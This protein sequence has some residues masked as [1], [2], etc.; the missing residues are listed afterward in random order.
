[1]TPPPSIAPT[2]GSEAGVILERGRAIDRFIVLGLVGRGGMGE[3]YAAYDPELDRKVAIKLLRARD[4]AADAKTRLLREAQAIAKLQ[5]PNV[6]VVYDVGTFGDSVFIAMEF[7]EGRTVGGWLEAGKRTRR[8]IMDVYL[9]AGRGLAAAHAAGLV[10][11]DFKPDN[12][13]VTDDGQVRVMDFGLARQVREAADEAN[14]AR[15]K[16]EAGGGLISE[17]LDPGYDPDA[18]LDF[19]KPGAADVR[20]TSGKYLSVK[21]TQTGAMLG[22]PAYMAPEQFAVRPTDARTDQFA[23]CVAVYEALYGQRPFEGTTMVTLMTSVTTGIVNP[24]PPK[25]NVPGWMRKVLL[26]GLQPHP[27][28]RFP[29]MAGLLAALQTDPTVRARRLAAGLGLAAC[30]VAAIW[31]ARSLEGTQ[32]AVCRGAAGHFAG[33]WEPGERHSPRR[34]AIHDAFVRTGKAYAPQAFASVTRL[35]D[36]YVEK[37]M[38]ADVEA[39]EATHVRGEQSNE[40]LDLRMG[41]LQER[42]TSVHALT[43]L[44]ANA[45][46]KVVENAVGAASALPPLDRCSDVPVLKAVIKPPADP[47]TVRRVQSVRADLARFVALRDAGHC[48]DAQRMQDAL[49]GSARA[50]G[51]QPLLGETLFEAARLGD[52]CGDQVQMLDLFRESV[53]VALVARHDEVAASA[54]LLLAGVLADRVRQPAAGRDWLRVGR[55]LLARLG[56]RPQVEAWGLNSE[57]TIFAAEGKGAD[58]LDAY[59]RALALKEHVVGRDNYDTILGLMNVGVGF[60]YAGKYEESRATSAASREAMSRLLGPD[61]PSVALA[62]NNEGESLNFLHR[63]AEAH[64]AFQRAYDIWRRSEAD[65]IFLSY[66]LTGLGIAYLGEGKADEAVAPL[67]EALRV[68]VAKQFDPERVG[69]TRFALARALWSRPADRERA[70]TLARQ[71]LADYAQVKTPTVPPPDVAAWLR[72]PSTRA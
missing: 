3:V 48:G 49:I 14:A 31:G 10:H 59:Q 21:L 46:G 33:I 30:I 23:F 47:A 35:L 16:L 71:A 39:C 4:N 60:E 57:A 36:G 54:A 50:T 55:A 27:D 15:A 61:H 66:A 11:R 17:T 34:A 1:M 41:C 58:S 6:V 56:G 40:V 72:A 52:N 68:R 29:S 51:Y 8:E 53:T 24:P 69:E 26:R 5:H 44:F 19:R 28:A 42:L 63:S 2:P 13:M 43:D 67:E 70:R 25:A 37:W 38:R 12:V 62:S 9:A 18:T 45:D 65:A 64:V 22:T 32:Q 7:V 20:K